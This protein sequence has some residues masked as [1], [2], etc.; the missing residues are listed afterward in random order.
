MNRGRVGRAALAA[1]NEAAERER[2]PFL[3]GFLICACLWAGKAPFRKGSANLAT[4]GSV[5]SSGS[6][7]KR[8]ANCSNSDQHLDDTEE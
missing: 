4:T 1:R 6:S 3:R 5:P 2:H 8:S 7:C